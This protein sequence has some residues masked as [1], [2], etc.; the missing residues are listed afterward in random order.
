M[1]NRREGLAFIVLTIL[2]TYW[3]PVMFWKKHGP[4]MAVA[5]TAGMVLV[6]LAALAIRKRI[7]NG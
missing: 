3:V 2:S 6:L 7:T 5:V 1:K 4:A